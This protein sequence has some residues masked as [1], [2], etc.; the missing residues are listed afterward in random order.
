MKLQHLL[1]YVHGAFG[2]QD[3]LCMLCRKLPES[4]YFVV[5][6]NAD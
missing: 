4:V 2:L 1:A 3:V 5:I 6:A